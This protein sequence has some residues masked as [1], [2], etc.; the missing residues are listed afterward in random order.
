MVGDY[1]LK[2]QDLLSGDFEDA[3]CIGGWPMDDHPPGGFDRSD[4]PPN[5]VLR[6][7]E[8]FN[9]PLRSLYSRSISNLFMAGRNISASH[10]AFTSTRVMGTCAVEGQAVGTAAALCLEHGLTPRQLYEQKTRLKQ[11]Q[12][13]LLRDDH[14]IKARVN[15]DPGD[16]ARTARVTASAERDDA[17]A[18]LILDGQLRDIPGGAI[19]HW[20]ARMAPEGAWIQL[21]WD[22]PQRI[23][24]VQI[25]FDSGFQRELTLSS[26]DNVVRGTVR[27]P[28]PETARDYAVSCRRPDGQSTT[29]AEVKSNHQRL[30]RHRFE[31]VETS[32][33]RLHIT[34]TNGDEFARVFEIR[35]YGENS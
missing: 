20:A 18:K 34:A 7:P 21:E 19:H 28:Q 27:A 15:E 11:L 10:V 24:E 31:P 22:R 12:Q 6:P 8:V 30:C 35:C 2:Q 5:T 26:Q 3:V 29:L 25:T 17:P 33:V 13:A 16:L 14:T 32:S 9:I 4:I 1:M 23:R